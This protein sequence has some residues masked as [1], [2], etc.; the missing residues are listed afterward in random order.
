MFLRFSAEFSI[1]SFPY[2]DAHLFF[3]LHAVLNCSAFALG[4]DLSTKPLEHP[5]L[6]GTLQYNLVL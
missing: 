6:T 5:S 2:S 1:S 3:I 4:I